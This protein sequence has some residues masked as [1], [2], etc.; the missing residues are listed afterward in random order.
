[1]GDFLGP[2]LDS[3]QQVG[4]K[5]IIIGGMVGKVT[6]IAQGEVITH[7]RRNP[8]NTKLLADIAAEVGADASV[9]AEIAEGETARFAGERMD[10]LG[11]AKAF[12]KVL[13]SRVVATLGARYPNTFSYRILMCDFDGKKLVDYDE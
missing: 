12:Y 3:A 6:K 2:A 10:E 8:V 9:C 5:Q 13:C 4:I 11:L 7:A 1:M